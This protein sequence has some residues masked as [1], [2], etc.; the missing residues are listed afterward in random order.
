VAVQFN[1]S[2][3]FYHH[4]LSFDGLTGKVFD[5]RGLVFIKIPLSLTGH[6]DLFVVVFNEVFYVF[7]TGNTG[8]QYHR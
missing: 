6:N 7:F 4:S 8:I 1:F 3:F 2:S 5:H